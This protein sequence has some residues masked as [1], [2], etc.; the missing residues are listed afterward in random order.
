MAERADFSTDL[1]SLLSLV[2]GAAVVIPS[3]ISLGLSLIA[4][5]ERWF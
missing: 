1:V 2:F 5:A 4:V 3:L